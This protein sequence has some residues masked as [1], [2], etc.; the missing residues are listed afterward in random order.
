MDCLKL[1][2]VSAT[3][4]PLAQL[5]KRLTLLAVH[6]LPPQSKEYPGIFAVVA[7]NLVV[8]I[9]KYARLRMFEPLI[10]LHTLSYSSTRYQYFAMDACEAHQFLRA[11]T[12]RTYVGIKRYTKTAV[13]RGYVRSG[14]VSVDPIFF[15][16]N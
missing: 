5:C 13:P 15:I 11:T 2:V 9:Y 6:L 4:L 10:L 3:G 12:A 7:F 16:R 8:G 1:V 14:E